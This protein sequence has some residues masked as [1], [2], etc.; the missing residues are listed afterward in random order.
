MEYVAIFENGKN[1]YCTYTPNLA[2][3]VVVNET[4]AEV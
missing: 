2:D 1:S 3:C 4:T